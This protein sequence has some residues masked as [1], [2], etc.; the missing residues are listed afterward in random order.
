MKAEELRIGNYVKID[1]G[2]G[3]VAFIMDKSFCNEYAN[4]DYNIT[5][6]MGDGIFREEEEDKVE[7]IPLTEEIL[8]NCG[9]EYIN[10]DYKETG[11]VSPPDE[12]SNRYRIVHLKNDFKLFL[13]TW[14]WISVKY[15]HEFQNL[16]FCNCPYEFK[17]TI[18]KTTEEIINLVSKA[19]EPR[20]IKW[21]DIN[22]D[23][24]RF[25]YFGVTFRVTKELCV[26]EVKELCLHRTL[27][28]FLLELLLK[29]ENINES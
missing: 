7:G 1:E 22:N 5:V 27:A 10:T 20:S 6:E 26:D 15:V 23:N 16:F 11:M 2:I 9:F 17:Y 4:D 13:K 25:M 19:L 8:L 12:F 3:K 28:A 24:V 21:V 14:N 29:K 18:M